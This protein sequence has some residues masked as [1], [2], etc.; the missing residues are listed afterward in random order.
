MLQTICR[1][2]LYRLQAVVSRLYGHVSGL[3]RRTSGPH[4]RTIR[5]QQHVIGMR[6]AISGL[7]CVATRLHKDVAYSQPQTSG[8][9]MRAGRLS[10]PAYGFVSC[11]KGTL[12]GK[13]KTMASPMRIATFNVE[14]LDDKP[15]TKP[16]IA[17]RV[18]LMQAQLNRIHADILCLQEVNSAT[19]LDQ[20]IA[21]TAYAGFQRFSTNNDETQNHGAP[22]NV[23]LLSR[24]PITA[25]EEILN[26]FNSGPLYQIQTAIPPATTTERI[27][28]TRSILHCQVQLS[29]NETL[30]VIS[31]HLKS[32]LPSDIP[33]QKQ[34]IPGSTFKMWKSASASAEGSF[35]S[36]M[37]RVGQALEARLLVDSLFDV[38]PNALILVC[39][40]FNAEADEVPVAALRGNVED[41]ENPGLANRVLVPCENTIPEQARYSLI[42]HGKGTMIDH[43]L[44]SRSLLAFYRGAEIHNELLHDES[45][46]FATDIKFPE[47]DH[48]PVVAA[49]ELP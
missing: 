46:A 35:I 1:Q 43:V 26:Q 29:N 32:K 14:N 34:N 8:L 15:N 7:Q 10:G 38:N 17:V 19:A 48:A 12:E 36:S 2:T 4:T 40:D 47:S 11:L 9:H 45:S 23:V 28:W 16:P 39:G 42:H 24:F 22:Q 13:H 33:G 49:F 5:L 30:H 31:F 37:R 21:G 25:S 20:L 18:A 41:T 27:T 6:M 3:Q 44:V